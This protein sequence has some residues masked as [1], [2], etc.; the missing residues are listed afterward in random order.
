MRLLLDTHVFLWFLEGNNKVPPRV[1]AVIT[2][3]E[4]ELLLSVASIW[5][6][7]IKH[8]LGKLPL[9][10]PPASYLPIQRDRHQIESLPVVESCMEALS[11]LPLHHSDPFDRLLIAQALAHEL[12]LVTVDNHFAAYSV[13]ILDWS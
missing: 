4:N 10:G 3:S 1:R 13:P 12:T 2:D 8:Q 6:A 7:V 9:P 11:T 5:E